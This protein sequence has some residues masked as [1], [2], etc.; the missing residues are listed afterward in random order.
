MSAWRDSCLKSPEGL[1]E[2]DLSMSGSVAGQVAPSLPVPLCLQVLSQGRKNKLSACQQC[3]SV[4]SSSLLS[5]CLSPVITALAVGKSPQ[6]WVALFAY[7]ARNTCP[8]QVET[9][10]LLLF[11]LFLLT[12][13][14]L[15]TGVAVPLMLTYV[16]G[17]VALSLCRNHWGGGG[18]RKKAE[19]H[20]LVELENLAKCT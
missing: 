18:T 19:E 11:L 17:A 9:T 13:S 12:P 20:S 14:S 3:L 2:L 4:A 8:P 15:P 6:G 7:A 5:L 10:L 16:Y 1:T